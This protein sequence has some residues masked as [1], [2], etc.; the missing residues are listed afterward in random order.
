[1]SRIAE[2]ELEKARVIIRRLMWMFN[3]ESG[4]MGW[5]VGEGYAEALFHSEK[6]K[7]EYLQIYLSYLWPE[8][9]YL[10]FPPAQ[11][12]LAWGIGRLAQKY[13]QEVI[14]LSGNEYLTLHL[15]SPDPTVCFLSLWS[16]AQFISLKNSL[17][18]EI[19]GKALKR[20]ADL[21]WKY[22]LFDGQS[23]KTYTTKDLE[24]LLFS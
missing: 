9:N 19:I 7:N 18:K 24:N 13:E 6:L 2:A 22:L 21:D 10:E 17:N 11:R 20:L 23:I 12:G 1:V 5:G 14:N 16:L 15:N 4:G 3:E 8:G